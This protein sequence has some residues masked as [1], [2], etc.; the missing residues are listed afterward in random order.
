MD[1]RIYKDR[2]QARKLGFTPTGIGQSLG[3]LVRGA[4][5]NRLQIDEREI[6]VRLRLVD[7]DRQALNQLK[8]YSFQTPAGEEVPLASLADFKIAQGSGTI[9][10]ENGRMRLRLRVKGVYRPS[11]HPDRHRCVRRK[12]KW[13]SPS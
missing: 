7:Q 3:Y 12:I 10:R 13:A 4:N 11:L 8:S 9:R 2:E 5:L 1:I 6:D